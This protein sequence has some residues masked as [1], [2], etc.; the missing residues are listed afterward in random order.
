MEEPIRVVVR[1]V[2]SAELRLPFCTPSPMYTRFMKRRVHKIDRAKT[3]QI[4]HEDL[5]KGGDF[6]RIWDKDPNEIFSS[7]DLS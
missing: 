6:E 5:V 2:V 7:W 4:I 1:G 3:R